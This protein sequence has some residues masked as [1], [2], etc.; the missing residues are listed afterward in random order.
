MRPR[1]ISDLHFEQIT[2]RNRGMMLIPI[3][4]GSTTLSVTDM[5]PVE[6]TV[7]GTSINRRALIPLLNIDQVFPERQ[8]TA[9]A[10]LP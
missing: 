4:G 7:M 3:P 10:T 8:N 2:C 6:A 9:N 1:T 5:M